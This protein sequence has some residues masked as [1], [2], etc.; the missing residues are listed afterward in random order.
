MR[1][2][3]TEQSLRE[4]QKMIEQHYKVGA[5][6]LGTRV[7]NLSGMVR[8]L[9]H[10]EPVV[11]IRVEALSYAA[12]QLVAAT[13]IEEASSGGCR[14]FVIEVPSI[15][16]VA[17]LFFA[18]RHNGVQ[19]SIDC[20]HEIA[21]QVVSASA[22]I[23]IEGRVGETRLETASGGVRVE[24]AAEE[25]RAATASGEIT[26][27]RAEQHASLRSAS[28]DITLHEACGAAEIRTASGRTTLGVAHKPFKISSASGRTKVGSAVAGGSSESASGAISIAAAHHGSCEIRTASGRVSVGVCRGSEVH[29]EASTLSGKITS[30]IDLDPTPKGATPAKGSPDRDGS[31]S[32]E[33][34]PQEDGAELD[35]RV[36]TL[37]GR[38]EILRARP[39]SC[40]QGQGGEEGGGKAEPNGCDLTAADAAD[41]SYL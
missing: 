30:E 35:L 2:Q 1:D 37:S 28:G 6:R 15:K 32:T 17:P 40:G 8:I 11:R 26:V 9:T 38:I 41:G 22:D 18:D 27:K 10:D 19:V 24:V 4:E 33:E 21:V 13:R 34:S 36:T 14:E 23:E 39:L 20:P 3:H 31:E 25:L 5:E 12:E 7:R 16:S 29:L